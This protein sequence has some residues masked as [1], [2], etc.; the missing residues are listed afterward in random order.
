MID[1]VLDGSPSWEA[2]WWRSRRQDF[3]ARRRRGNKLSRLLS[4]GQKLLFK[5]IQC[6]ENFLELLSH[7][8]VFAALFSP[9]MSKWCNCCRGLS[10]TH[11]VRGAGTPVGAEKRC[12][13][14]HEQR[15][16]GI[17][18]DLFMS[19]FH[20][21]HLISPTF[22]GKT[23]SCKSSHVVFTRIEIWNSRT[24]YKAY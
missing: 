7:S 15:Q 16:A 22:S 21:L 3:R 4:V 5:R 24:L 14:R 8:T 10:A 6:L 9:L 18:P 12:G 20:F 11:N 13:R 2:V 23:Y 17:F 19:P 1:V